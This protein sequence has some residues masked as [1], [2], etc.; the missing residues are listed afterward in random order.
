MSKNLHR[1]VYFHQIPEGTKFATNICLI[2]VGCCML[3]GHFGHPMGW[4]EEMQRVCV[5][6]SLFS[7]KGHILASQ[8]KGSS[9][10]RPEL[11]IQERCLPT[12]V[13]TSGITHIARGTE[14]CEELREEHSV[15][16]ISNVCTEDRSVTRGWC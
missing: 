10:Q 9:V 7:G 8:V 12:K 6:S 16:S 2:Q 14:P 5:L 11:C 13:A 1:S 15:N 3:F 4:E